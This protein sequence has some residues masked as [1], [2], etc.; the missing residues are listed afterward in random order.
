MDYRGVNDKIEINLF[1]Y[2]LHTL[3]STE[4]NSQNILCKRKLIVA[5]VFQKQSSPNY[6]KQQ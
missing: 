5:K 2:L 6:R 3:T 1:K 4:N